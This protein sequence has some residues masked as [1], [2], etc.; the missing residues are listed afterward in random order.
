[1]LRLAAAL[2]VAL[3]SSSGTYAETVYH[4][5]NTHEP[6]SLDP[7]KASTVNEAHILVD[8]FESLVAYDARVDINTMNIHPSRFIANTQ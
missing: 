8:L 1:M 2:I 4:R 6:G 7:H 5:G 3:I